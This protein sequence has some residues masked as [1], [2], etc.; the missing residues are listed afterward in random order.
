M[1]QALAIA[2]MSFRTIAKSGAGLIL[3][4]PIAILIEIIFGVIAGVK[5]NNN[6]QYNY[7]LSYS[8]IK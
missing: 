4:A 3:L 5:A 6:E 1:R 8:F 2:G 7:P